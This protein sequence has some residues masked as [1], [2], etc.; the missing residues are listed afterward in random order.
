MYQEKTFL[1]IIPARGG[2][3]GIPRKNIRDLA[4]KPLVAWTI[5]EAAKSQYLDRCVI[6]TDD[7]EIAD[8]ARNFGGDVPFMRPAELAQDGT[9][10][11]DVVLHVV[12]EITGYDYVVLLQPTSPLRT[13]ND[14]DDGIMFCL[15]HGTE[16][17]VGIVEA[18]ESPYWMYNLD[19]ANKMSAIISLSEEK[20]YQRQKLPKAYSVNGAMYINS[21]HSLRKTKM[22][23]HGETI[24]YIM[25]RERSWDI[26]TLLDFK[27]VE[28]LMQYAKGNKC[29][30]P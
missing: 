8:I 26:D 7:T 17:C 25:P 24:G 9:P 19:K 18:T 12:N 4:G 23:I 13:A 14:I 6:S 2:S 3:K 22:F 29:Y 16:S 5:E 28:M 10:S 21:V 30:L 11:I 1:G 20:K 27:I 15:S